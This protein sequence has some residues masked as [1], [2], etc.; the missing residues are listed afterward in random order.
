MSDTSPSPTPPSPLTDSPWFWLLVFSAA[1]AV[2]LVLIFPRYQARQRRLEMQYLAREEILRRRA[3]GEPAARE[4]GDEGDAPPPATG[5]LIIPLWPLA[6]LSG[7]GVCF[8]SYMLFRSRRP[9]PDA[10]S[11]SPPEALGGGPPS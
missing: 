5:E 3:E 11:P 7:G 1:A 4:A 10:E 9:P 8:S 2:A 6:F